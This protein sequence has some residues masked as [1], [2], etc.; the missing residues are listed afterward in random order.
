MSCIRYVMVVLPILVASVNADE[1]PSYT[2][3]DVV[4][5]ASRLPVTELRTPRSVT[6]IGRDGIEASPASSVA[7]LL[8]TV[9]GLDVRSRGPFGVQS[10]VGIRG[11]TFEQ[12]LILVDGVGVNDAQTGHH[13]LDVALSVD[14]IERIEV[15]RGAS[16]RVHGRDAFGGVINIVTRSL[17]QTGLNV[18]ATSGQYGYA[19]FSASGGIVGNG[20]ALRGSASIQRSDG[21]RSGAEFDVR[22]ATLGTSHQVGRSTIDLSSGLSRKEFG[23]YAFYSAKYP[24][25]WEATDTYYVSAR[26]E[27]PVGV[28]LLSTSLSWRR[29]DD[30]FILNRLDPGFYRNLHTTDALAAR[31]QLDVPW[32]IGWISLGGEI[33]DDAIESASLG[34]HQRRRVGVFAEQNVRLGSRMESSFGASVFHHTYF[35]WTTSPGVDVSVDVT[36][37]S[38]AYASVARAYRV[39]TFTDLYYVSPANVGNAA[40]DPESGWTLEAG[41]RR[42]T[43]RV[44]VEFGVFRRYGSNLIDWARADSTQ[45]WTAQNTTDVVTDGFDARTEY[46][47]DE[48]TLLGIVTRIGV[49]YAYLRTDNLSKDSKYGSDHLRHQLIGSVEHILPFGVTASWSAR[50]EVRR[51]R[52]ADNLVANYVVD[53]RLRRQFGAF[54]TFI[55]GTNL[56]DDE[57]VDAGFAPQPGRWLRM[58]VAYTL[59]P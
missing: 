36:D 49:S 38:V 12:T 40:L 29:H 31:F 18:S 32:T 16:S 22:T 58:G 6:V 23:A 45:P 25:E 2:V 44:H 50:E 39:P 33:G 41:W 21:H 15:V 48:T 1:L 54:S 14:D 28:T 27:S 52:G 4:V 35:G 55:E 5:T 3:D 11:G 47:P 37:N 43:S 57:Y 24:D 9:L 26:S 13:S 17:N 8:K 46:R 51:E 53:V 10:D 19:G 30:D 59:H 7:D 42:H 34:N 20:H 56:L